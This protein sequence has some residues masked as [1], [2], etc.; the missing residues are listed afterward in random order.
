MAA[1]MARL[2]FGLRRSFSL[3]GVDGSNT[4]AA[5]MACGAP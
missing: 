4:S 5:V 2:Q 1:T 3:M